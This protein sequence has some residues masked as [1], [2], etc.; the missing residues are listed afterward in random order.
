MLTCFAETW[1]W[2]NI[3]IKKK[4][5]KKVQKTPGTLWILFLLN[6][7]AGAGIEKERDGNEQGV[8]NTIQRSVANIFCD[9]TAPCLFKKKKKGI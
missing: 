7:Q 3:Q 6:G 5:K 1:P 4:E 2:T 9:T 8:G